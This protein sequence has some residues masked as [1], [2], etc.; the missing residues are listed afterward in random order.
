MGKRT[1]GLLYVSSNAGGWWPRLKDEQGAS[2][3][4]VGRPSST[5]RRP[6]AERIENATE[7]AQHLVEC[8]S[9]CEGFNG[10]L[11]P[12]LLAD[13]VDLLSAI[14]ARFEM[15]AE[16]TADSFPGRAYLSDINALKAR[17]GV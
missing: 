7:D 1:A 9:T 16:R 6:S 2:M 12:G 17:A 5:G 3:A 8:W 15:E 13:A 14:G 10:S 4:V 11:A